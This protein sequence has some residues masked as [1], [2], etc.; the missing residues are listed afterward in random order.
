[1]SALFRLF[2]QGSRGVAPPPVLVPAGAIRP[3]EDD[4]A[5]IAALADYLALMRESGRIWSELQADA[6]E[7]GAADAYLNTVEQAGHAAW[8]AIADPATLLRAE[9]ALGLAAPDFAALHAEAADLGGRRKEKA[10]AKLDARFFELG[11]RDA[12]D[13]A[14]AGHI[15]AL[16]GLQVVPDADY[17]AAIAALCGDAEAPADRRRD[18]L[19]ERLERRLTDPF[20]AGIAIVLGRAAGLYAPFFL[21]PGPR[22]ER[23]DGRMVTE[24]L[25]GSDGA[26]FRA[27]ALTDRV[28]LRA[29]A[30]GGGWQALGHLDFDHIALAAA[31]ARE[32]EVAQ[33][34]LMGLEELE[35]ADRLATLVF[36]STRELPRTGAEAAAFHLGL[37]GA[38]S[39]AVVVFPNV[40]VLVDPATNGRLAEF[41]RSTL[42]AEAAAHRERLAKL[43]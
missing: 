10:L 18:L 32:G 25:V 35:L 27:I 4:R 13:G 29:P 42:S 37:D 30:P 16:P 22:R 9:V 39:L 17:P 34:A 31:W 11:G 12:V 6:V 33:A 5:L 36:D 8:L 19:L 1:M 23:D 41:H 43:S 15:A 20:E 26:R 14:L 40:T 2:G 38:R 7:A 24:W 21:A 3:G 28:A